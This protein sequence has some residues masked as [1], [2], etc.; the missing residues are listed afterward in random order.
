MRPGVVTWII[1]FLVLA[2]LLTSTQ[3]G[4]RVPDLVPH[5]NE[6]KPFRIG[7]PAGWDVKWDYPLGGYGVADLVALGPREDSYRTNIGV[8]SQPAE[9]AETDDFLKE[10]G[11]DVIGDIRQR[12]S[13]TI[14]RVPGVIETVNTRAVLFAIEYD[15]I[16]LSQ[17]GGIVV[18]KSLDRVWLIFGSSSTSAAWRNEPLFEA[19][20]ASFEFVTTPE[21]AFV[22][23]LGSSLIFLAIAGSAAVLGALV[24]F[25][26]RHEL[27]F[28]FRT[29]RDEGRV[30][31]SFEAPEAPGEEVEGPPEE[32]E[33]PP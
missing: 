28:L 32:L 1:A 11:W 18:S 14:S 8:D 27:L 26:R 13:V 7:L 16:P 23:P 25:R 4:A 5:A 20:I 22:A 31:G 21:P 6:D 15:S 19:V 10:M 3:A 24:L 29:I 9:V 30:P 33:G 2:I 12:R 17:V